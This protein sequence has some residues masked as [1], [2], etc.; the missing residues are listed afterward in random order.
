M[1]DIHLTSGDDTYTATNAGDRI[2]G[3]DGN[4]ALT[5]SAGGN[6]MYGSLGNDTLN[7][8]GGNDILWGDDSTSVMGHNVLNGNG[9][10]D[11]IISYSWYDQ[12]TGGKGDDIVF[13]YAMTTGQI[14]DGGTG[15]DTIEIR[16]LSDQSENV[17]LVFGS[18]FSP[19]VGAIQ[20][21]TYTNFETLYFVG[22]TGANTIEGGANNDTL[23]N[24]YTNVAS[25]AAGSLS[26]MGGDDLLQFNGLPSAGT[27]TE[28][29]DGGDGNDRLLWSNGFA[30]F[31]ALDVNA[32]AGTMKDAGTTFAHF[33]GIEALSVQTFFGATGTIT[34]DG[35]EG[36]DFI[37][38]YASS[39]NLTTNGGDDTVYVN[40][41]TATVDAGAGNDNVL[42]AFNNDSSCTAHGGIGDDS[43]TT[44]KGQSTLYGDDGNDHLTAQNGHSSVYGGAGDDSLYN[45]SS[46]SMLGSGAA[47]IDGGTGH[48][49]ASIER[50]ASGTTYTLDFTQATITLADGTLIKRC[51]GISFVASSGN[52]VMTASNS[53]V[54]YTEN[55]LYGVGGDDTLIASSNGGWLDGGSGV[56]LLVASASVDYMY[57]GIADYE[58]STK[59]V[60]VDLNI[61]TAQGGKGYAHGDLLAATVL[62]VTGSAFNDRILG[63]QFTNT[64]NG[65]D[66]ADTLTAGTGF[67]DKLTGGLGKDTFVYTGAADSTGMSYDIITDF[68]A[69]QD[70]FK[71]LSGVSDIDNKVGSGTLSAGSFDADLGAAMT[72]HLGAHHAILFAPD[73]G[74]LAG[75]TFLIVDQDGAAGYLSGSDLVIDITGA[76]HLTGLGASDFTT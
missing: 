49:Y 54:G 28:Q 36:N 69:K 63:D 74:D 72:G 18:T 24:T 20:G 62:S 19:T 37:D 4:D 46:Y 17:H 57:S 40:S 71:V 39:S 34:V 50:S 48:D 16:S 11:Q 66:G 21:A 6:E 27:G 15:T 41:G 33:T 2:F 9:G 75:K 35:T 1:T 53:A 64:F 25:F 65:G 5:A 52:D 43:L 32:A 29:I 12:I 14:V 23:I 58:H 3:D 60:T 51:E 45:T 56:N 67:H 68:D 70:H 7:G 30:S 8:A 22:G 31:S 47:V 55:R 13:S 42:I 59:G 73:A 26:G 38:I 44:G 76:V 10:N 61:T